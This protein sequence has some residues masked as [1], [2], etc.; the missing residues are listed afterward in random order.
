MKRRFAK[1]MGLMIGV[2]VSFTFIGYAFATQIVF[3]DLETNSWYEGAVLEMAELGIIT[4]Y[5]DGKYLP[6]NFVNRAEMAV[7]VQRLLD[8]IDAIEEVVAVDVVEPDLL[9]EVQSKPL[10]DSI[11]LNVPFTA[12]APH[13]D[14]SM[15]Y[16]EACEEASMVMVDHYWTGKI[17]NADIADHD[18]INLVNWQ[19][20]NGYQVDADSEEMA[21]IGEANY[22]LDGHTFLDGDVTLENIRYFLAAGY[23]VILPVAGQTLENPNFSYPG[24]PYHVIVLTGYDQNGF[25]ANDPGTRL[26]ESYYYTNA[27]IDTAIHDW[28]GSK[29]TITGGRRAM[30]VFAP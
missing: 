8:Y 12:Q 29:S 7:I 28:T 1:L 5:D 15:P 19:T 10:P 27:V 26:G 13:S 6:D 20:A 14:W 3:N 17:L 24:P 16:Q 23:P 18:I 9:K 2:A 30:L 21:I 11:A 4:G 22:E 25:T